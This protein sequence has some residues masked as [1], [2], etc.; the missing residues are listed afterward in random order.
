MVL[1]NRLRTRTWT[2]PVSKPIFD[3][4]YRMSG[5]IAELYLGERRL[6]TINPGDKVVMYPETAALHGRSVP[7][8]V[9][10]VKEVRPGTIEQLVSMLDEPAAVVPFGTRLRGVEQRWEIVE[11]Y[12]DNLGHLPLHQTCYI[13]FKP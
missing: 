13:G 12:R 11:W 3:E 5:I 7:T 8:V 1:E 4:A 9:R 6:E 10:E 2:I